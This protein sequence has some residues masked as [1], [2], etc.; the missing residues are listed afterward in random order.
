MLSQTR[1]IFLRRAIKVGSLTGVQNNYSTI[2]VSEATTTA[3]ASQWQP[4]YHFKYIKGIAGLNKL[5]LYQAALTSA[6]VPVS[7]GLEIAEKLPAGSAEI[8]G[9]I[10]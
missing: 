10:G 7:M 9:A 8:V 5:K 6:A 4:I 2:G 3:V 1:Q